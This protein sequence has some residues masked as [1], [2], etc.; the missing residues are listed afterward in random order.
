LVP[1]VIFCSSRSKPHY[2]GGAVYSISLEELDP[3][4]C[5]NVLFICGMSARGRT[6]FFEPVVSYLAGLASPTDPDCR[7]LT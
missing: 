5:T 4:I 3:S 6:E 2:A 7:L 1:E